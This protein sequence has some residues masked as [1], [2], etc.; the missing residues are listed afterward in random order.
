MCVVTLHRFEQLYRLL[1][2][3]LQMEKAFD[4]CGTVVEGF[5]VC[6][7]CDAQK[8]KQRTSQKNKTALKMLRHRIQKRT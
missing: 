5:I 7:S 3:I 4:D 6:V 2:H 1:Y 8:M